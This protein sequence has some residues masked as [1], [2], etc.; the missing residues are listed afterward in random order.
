MPQDKAAVV[1]CRCP[2]QFSDG[3]LRNDEPAATR[4]LSQIRRAGADAG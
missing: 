3:A 2:K 1:K 4:A